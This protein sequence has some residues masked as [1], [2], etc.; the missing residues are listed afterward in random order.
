MSIP[1]SHLPAPARAIAAAVTSAVEAARAGDRPAFEEAAGEL[2]LLD[3]ERVAVLLGAVVR[4]V[5]EDRHPGGLTGDDL[6]DV[7]VECVRAVA[8]WYPAVDPQILG[9]VLTGALGVHDADPGPL[10]AE[11]VTRH[12][13]LLLASAQRPLQPYLDGA[14]AE[15]ARAETVE[16]P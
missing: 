13:T 7:L 14:F 1:W 16:M 9:T 12:A 8:A 4:A 10:G 15:V 5:L 6:R 11:D 3:R 2:A